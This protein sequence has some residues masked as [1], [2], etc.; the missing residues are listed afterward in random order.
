MISYIYK[1]ESETL[2]KESELLSLYNDSYTQNDQNDLENIIILY[3]QLA[4]PEPESNIITLFSSINEIISRSSFYFST[5]FPIQ[6]ILDIAFQLCQSTEEK[7]RFY[8]F[9]TIILI[10]ENSYY[11]KD[12]NYGLYFFNNNF[13]QLLDLIYT[14][15]KSDY[16]PKIILNAIALYSSSS[17]DARNSILTLFQFD[18]FEQFIQSRNLEC[19]KFA[20]DCFTGFLKYPLNLPDLSTLYNLLSEITEIEDFDIQLKILRCIIQSMNQENWENLF[21]ENDLHHF[22]QNSIKKDD[23]DFKELGIEILYKYS[24]DFSLKESI[25]ETIISEFFCEEEEDKSMQ[26]SEKFSIFTAKIFTN[27]MSRSYLREILLKLGM[28]FVL[29]LF[30]ENGT[31]SMK[32]ASSQTIIE[33]IKFGD[34]N[35]KLLFLD[36]NLM[37]EFFAIIQSDEFQLTI[38]IL[39]ALS[40]VFYSACE[41]GSDKISLFVENLNECEGFDFLEILSNN[42]TEEVKLRAQCLLKNINDNYSFV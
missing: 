22:V 42:E 14:T 31:Y 38:D 32:V 36:F 33:L 27:H 3:N 9:K 25:L 7:I 37:P 18:F 16:H 40:E 11:E 1:D 35:Q 34:M 23:Q 5:G 21:I 29:Q 30:F 15:N 8:S 12:E 6:E 24:A 20:I 39:D 2:A 10:L 28:I 17:E 41:I 4:N 26:N 13:H 19:I